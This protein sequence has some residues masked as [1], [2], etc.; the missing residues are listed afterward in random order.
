[1]GIWRKK[2]E[3]VKP[4]SIHEL[5]NNFLSLRSQYKNISIVSTGNN[6][7]Y[8]DN[9]PSVDDSLVID[10]SSCNEIISF[11]E[12]HGLITLE[13]GVTYGQLADYL[14]K[15]TSKWIA[16]VHGGGPD[17]SVVGNALERGY[18][19]TPFADHFSAV[20]S[21]KA[22]LNNG[23][24]Y[25]GAFANIGQEKLDKLF[26]YG[27]GPYT[28]G[29]FSQSGVGIVYEMTIKL[30]YCPPFVEM[31]YF[32]L[33]DGNS[34]ADAVEAIKLCKRDLGS[35]IA[36]I[37]LINEER[38]LS[39]VC[40]YPME[41][42]K[43]GEPLSKEEL[44]VAAKKYMI[45]PW[46]VVG[47]MYGEKELVDATR[48]VV[49]KHFKHIKK[50]KFFFNTANKKIYNLIGKF[51]TNIGQVEKTRMI[52]KL[53]EAYDIL[54]GIPN[55]AALKLAYWKNPNRGL[56]SQTNLNPSRDKCGLIWYSPLVE[57]NGQNAVDY[58]QFIKDSSQKFGIN[59]LITL[60]T[61]DDLC[62]DSTVP[63]VFDRENAADTKRAYEYY[64]YLFKEGA[65][66]GYFPYRLN[67]ESQKELNLQCPSLKFDSINP[68]R[69][70]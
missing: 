64:Q 60:T 12:Y 59:S 55:N 1:M 30:A 68:D 62:F 19:L 17:C 36:G 66:R 18:G 33:M 11:D 28:D 23:E 48:K 45:S 14:K 24:I 31:F 49:L 54:T 50:R 7:G 13:P 3:V 6:W 20:Q 42:I 16:P 15:L 32:N 63:I 39:M 57:M 2:I 51:F 56:L 43:S 8:G 38:C 5:K 40:E 37:N 69:Y 34:L 10:L 35:N 65:K 47:M 53:L 61:I 67:I 27:V 52:N 4:K 9:A 29:I 22:I 26:R 21:L 41:K 25:Q 70:K 46:L 58:V 44:K